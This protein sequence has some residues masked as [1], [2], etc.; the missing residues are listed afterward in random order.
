[1]YGSTLL[2]LTVVGFLESL[3]FAKYKSYHLW[4]EIIL[5]LPFRFGYLLLIFSALNIVVR[6]SNTMMRKSG[7]GASLSLF[8]ILENKLSVSHC[9][10]WCQLLTIHLRFLSSVNFLLFPDYCLHFIMKQ[11]WILSIYFFVVYWDHQII[12]KLYSVNVM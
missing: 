8:L 1:M 5:L 9:W 7:K 11:Y 2:G 12:F 3:R 6:T 4:T 10:R